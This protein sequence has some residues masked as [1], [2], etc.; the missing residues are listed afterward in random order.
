MIGVVAVGL[1]R[2]QRLDLA[3]LGLLSSAL[4]CLDAFLLGVGVIFGF[5]ELDQGQRVFEIALEAREAPRLIL[6]LR[7]AR[8]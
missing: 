6:E 4:S 3:A 2:E 1:A 7:C 5:A 8:A